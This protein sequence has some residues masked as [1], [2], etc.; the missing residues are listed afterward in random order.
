MAR[1]IW[2]ERIL[3]GLSAVFG[4]LTLIVA[5]YGGAVIVAL[6]INAP[7]ALAIVLAALIVGA[8]LYFRKPLSVIVTVKSEDPR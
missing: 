8:A 5:A 1:E 7:D 6:A 3:T 2:V 4:L